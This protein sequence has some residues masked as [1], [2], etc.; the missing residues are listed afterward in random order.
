[1]RHAGDCLRWGCGRSAVGSNYACCTWNFGITCP[2]ALWWVSRATSDCSTEDRVSPSCPV[3]CD[4]GW[5]RE[6]RDTDAN[7]TGVLR[8]RTRR[9]R[10]PQPPNWGRTS[11]DSRWYGMSS[12]RGRGQRGGPPVRRRLCQ[13]PIHRGMIHIGTD[14]LIPETAECQ[15]L[16]RADRRLGAQRTEGPD[17]RPAGRLS[18]DGDVD[19][20]GLGLPEGVNWVG[21]DA[22]LGR[23]TLAA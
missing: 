17:D 21:S 15:R 1:M 18:P 14:G 12:P 11:P 20:L 5:V 6:A 19:C 16:R 13:R 9:P 8:R 4:V 2:A 10:C 7:P 3:A 22:M 23:A